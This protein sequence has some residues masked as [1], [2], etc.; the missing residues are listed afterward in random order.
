ME[1]WAV[2]NGFIA[3]PDKKSLQD[4]DGEIIILQVSLMEHQG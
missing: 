4:D 1:K 2:R 3:K